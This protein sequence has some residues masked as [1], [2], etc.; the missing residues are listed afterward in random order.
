MC[1]Q[2]KII[3]FK[4]RH[5]LVFYIAV[6]CMAGIGF[7]AGFV[8]VAGMGGS[9]YF[10]FKDSVCDTSL[11]FILAVIAAWFL[12]NDFSNR[13]IHHEI[14]LGYSRWSVLLV[15]ELP[16]MLSSVVL[17]FIYVVFIVFGT[18][19]KMGFSISVFK[20]GD[21]FWCVT[22]MIQLIALQSIITLITFICGKAPAAIATSVC[23]TIISCNALRNFFYGTF[24]EK[25]V[26]CFARDNSSE[27]L[28]QT[29]IVGVIT[30]VATIA[31]TYLVFRKREIK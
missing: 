7:W 19:C 21:I 18:A 8:K 22:V 26:F 11:T 23:F 13:T 4:F 29:S 14:T 16:V 6:L 5:F 24:F 28:I 9:A 25:T 10:A 12:G 17:H 20:A 27:T 1:N 3:F 15:R 30:L 2:F 31:L